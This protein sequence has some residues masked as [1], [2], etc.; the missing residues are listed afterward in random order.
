[1]HGS[2]HR[3]FIALLPPQ[4][5]QLEIHRLKQH[6][7]T[8]YQTQAALRSPPHIT[9]YPPFLW[10]QGSI[11][12]LHQSLATFARLK[13]PFL[14]ELLGFGSFPP[15][16]IYIHVEP[17]QA[18]AEIQVHLKEHLNKTLAITDP[19]S[20]PFTP[21]IT[22]AFR[23]LSRQHFKKAWAD[24][25]HRSFEATFMTKELTLLIHTGERWI[26]HSQFPFFSLGQLSEK[27]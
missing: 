9:L 12:D 20:R 26:L 19:S 11:S 21:H 6:F 10:D 25:Q 27:N 23:D 22:L 16:V 5:L 3:F 1:M 15:R 8:H 7:S 4:E 13:T 17:T 14:I 18:L 24:C 2:T